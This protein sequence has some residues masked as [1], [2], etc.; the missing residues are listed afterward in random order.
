M[1]PVLLEIGSFK[2]YSYG[3]MLS[4]TF[5]LVAYTLNME[6]HRKRMN[7]ELLGPTMMIAIVF[8]LFG[9]KLF[10]V[11]EYWDRFMKDPVKVFLKGSGLTFLGGFVVAGTALIT[12]LLLQRVS[13]LR[14]FD[15]CAPGTLLGYAVARLGCQ[16]SGDGDYGIPTDLP[17]GMAYP[18]GTVPT[19]EIVHPTPVYEMIY[20]IIFGSL[21]WK[22]RKQPR[23][24]GWIFYLYLIFSGTERFLIEF[25]RINPKWL[26]GLSQSQIIS[27]V[28][29][30][31]GVG[32]LIYLRDKAPAN[33]DDG[34]GGLPAKPG[35]APA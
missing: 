6:L 3:F 24:D 28:L 25:I 35:S 26:F 9:A 30:L 14:F 1:Y 5:V 10:D 18:N 22:L 8:G 31:I 7:V 34:R 20:A 2:I 16:L 15:C 33:F 12:Y 21:L 27:V 13:I 11:F 19:T 32:G 17:W 23:P 4:M 29:A